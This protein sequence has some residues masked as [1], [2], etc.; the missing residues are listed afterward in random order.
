MRAAGVAGDGEGGAVPAPESTAAAAASGPWAGLAAA[1]TH[2][3]CVINAA[4]GIIIEITA[5]L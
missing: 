4:D 1:A 2:G 3:E 5:L